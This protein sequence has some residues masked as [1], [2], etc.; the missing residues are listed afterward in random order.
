MLLSH[1][2]SGSEVRYV[3]KTCFQTVETAAKRLQTLKLSL[4]II[5]KTV[6]STGLYPSEAFQ[7]DTIRLTPQEESII[8]SMFLIILCV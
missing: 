4:G 3:C 6:A 5:R 1:L 2:S 7:M 8:Q